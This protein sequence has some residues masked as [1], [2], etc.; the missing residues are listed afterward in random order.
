MHCTR[1]H[2][3]C[4]PIGSLKAALPAY[5]QGRRLTPWFASLNCLPNVTC[6]RL[7]TPRRW[8]AEA[9][10]IARAAHTAAIAWPGGPDA[11]ATALGLPRDT[12]AVSS[13]GSGAAAVLPPPPVLSTTAAAA[14]AQAG[15]G[16]AIST[17][18]APSTGSVPTNSSG[19]SQD[20]A[21]ICDRAS[22]VQ[23]L[24][25]YVLRRDLPYGPLAAWLLCQPPRFVLRLRRQLQQLPASMLTPLTRGSQATSSM[26]RETLVQQPPQTQPPTRT[27][28]PLPPVSPDQLEASLA[29]SLHTCCWPGPAWL[30]ALASCATDQLYDRGFGAQNLGMILWSLAGLGY[31]PR[32][33][34]LDPWMDR[35]G[36]L[37]RDFRPENTVSVLCALSTWQE[38]PYSGSTAEADLRDVVER[39]V[40]A[41]GCR[42]LQLAAAAL[43]VLCELPP[44]PIAAEEGP[45]GEG[46]KGAVAW[47]RGAA[48]GRRSGRQAAPGGRGKGRGRDGLFVPVPSGVPEAVAGSGRGSRAGGGA[49]GGGATSA[50][51]AFQGAGGGRHRGL[52]PAVARLLV[53]RAVEVAGGYGP[54]RM[55]QVLRLLVVRLGCPVGRQ[56]LG[57]LLRSHAVGLEAMARGRGREGGEGG[58]MDEEGRV[59]GALRRRALRELLEAVM[60]V[61]GVVASGGGAAGSRDAGDA[62][63]GRAVVEGGERVGGDAGAGAGV[64]AGGLGEEQLVRL[65]P[66]R[67]WRAYLALAR[68]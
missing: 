50:A 64:G 58:G 38:L 23:Q 27:P 8:A 39:T 25:S 26:P 47:G 61:A 45:E 4:M 31:R 43:A 35:V 14:A 30:D 62:P 51:A 54:R 29:A 60:E 65:V 34:W 15:A 22:A 1:V 5:P 68:A 40:P 36:E 10:A 56:E 46:R 59:T 48:G 33:G 18:G 12:L 49:G 41:M 57:E 24:L 63:L 53:R 32:P 55:G 2:R 67:W 3:H 20:T 7:Y 21:L 19:S 6:R 9:L 13:P 37:A 66:P 44:P 52:H 17:K 16:V 42:E 11:A 28:A